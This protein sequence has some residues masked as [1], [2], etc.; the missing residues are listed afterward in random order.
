L[1]S[2]SLYSVSLVAEEVD[3]FTPTLKN[4]KDAAP[5]IDLATN[6][7]FEDLI[8]ILNIKELLNCNNPVKY[9]LAIKKLDQNFT[10][11]GNGLRAGQEIHQLLE[12]INQDTNNKSDYLTQLKNVQETWLAEF[13]PEKRQFFSELFSTID[14]FGKTEDKG[15]IYQG[16]N[17]L[18]CCT[19]RIN[20]NGIYIGLDKIDHF[21]GNGG[22]LFEEYI[23]NKTTLNEQENL[24][25]IMKINI[26]EEHSLW[27]LNG[28]S[29]KSYGDMASNW[30]GL[31]FYQKLFDGKNPYIRCNNGR[32]EKNSSTPFHIK[33]FLDESWNESYNC[34]SF[35]SQQELDVFQSNLKKAG[36]QCPVNKKVCAELTQKHKNDPLFVENAL[37]PLCSQKIENFIP[38]EEKVK[39]TW[40]EVALSFRGFTRKIMSALLDKKFT[41]ALYSF[42]PSLLKPST[43]KALNYGKEAAQVFSEMQSCIQSSKDESLKCLGKFTEPGIEVNQLDK[44]YNTLKSNTDFSDLSDCD[45]QSQN[46]EQFLHP[47][48]IGDLN[49]CFKTHHRTAETI[50]HVYFRKHKD[51]YKV[52]LIRF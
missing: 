11:I 47:K 19:N 22:L 44:F 49:L 50:G 41:K 36:T 27:G 39:V 8:E 26:R 3:D 24:K 23:K 18:T 7:L 28:L 20:V 42:F 12:L 5:I 52:V 10:A 46:L 48:P 17:Y 33:D 45:T 38:I 40:D 32:F 2:I 34:S 37:S 25:T 4:P 6:T 9:E 14:Y 51:E 15:S 13:A 30:H 43:I 21:F 35:G 1:S 16:L 29:P 31:H